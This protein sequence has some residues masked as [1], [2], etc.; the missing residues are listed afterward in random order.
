MNDGIRHTSFDGSEDQVGMS[1]GTKGISDDEE[2]YLF[3]FC[4]LE[5]L[6]HVRLALHH[7]S[8]RDDDG[9]LVERL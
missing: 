7:L 2:G 5:D 6:I 9:L 3:E 4:S 1:R 8:I